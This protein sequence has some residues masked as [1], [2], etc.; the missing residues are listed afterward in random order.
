[1]IKVQLFQGN[2]TETVEPLNYSNC[3]RYDNYM[4]IVHRLDSEGKEEPTFEPSET[5]TCISIPRMLR[6][7]TYLLP[8][9]GT[10]I[11]VGVTSATTLSRS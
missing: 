10:T 6:L 4:A 1:M 9:V 7:G 8:V 5:Q 2:M 11:S 3:K